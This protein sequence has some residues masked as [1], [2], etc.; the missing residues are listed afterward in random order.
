METGTE[1]TFLRLKPHLIRKL[2]DGA[3]LFD[4]C[5]CEVTGDEM[6]AG[7]RYAQ[8][9]T[10]WPNNEAAALLGLMEQYELLLIDKG[11][12][13]VAKEVSSLRA[14]LMESLN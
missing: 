14:R 13:F 7:V 1:D 11:F 10:E 8:G 6:R 2:Q 3:V 12:S 9:C 4:R 5:G